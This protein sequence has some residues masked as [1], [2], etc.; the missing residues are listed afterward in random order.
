MQRLTITIMAVVLAFSASTTRA[1]DAWVEPI[2]AAAEEHCAIRGYHRGYENLSGN[3]AAMLISEEPASA[4]FVALEFQR[5]D[6]AA[7]FARG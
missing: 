4:L 5:V 7:A 1:R 2:E 6:D 3:V